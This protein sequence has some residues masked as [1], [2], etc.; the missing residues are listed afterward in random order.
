MPRYYN[1][2]GFCR[3]MREEWARLFA[4]A[5]KDPDV[6]ADFWGSF[7]KESTPAER[8]ALQAILDHYKEHPDDGK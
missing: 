7:G 5:R 4:A 6:F 8:A 1:Q 3:L 2:E